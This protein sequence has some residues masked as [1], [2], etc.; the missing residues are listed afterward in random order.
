MA[1]SRMPSTAIASAIM[2]TSATL[3][4]GSVGAPAW[5]WASPPG[6]SE[7]AERARAHIT[8][9][10]GFIPPSPISRSMRYRPRRA[11]FRRVT[12]SVMTYPVLCEVQTLG[13]PP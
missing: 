5:A 9:L 8:P 10:L 13:A 3:G 7:I 2:V 12:G 1:S 4:V 11:A 6:A